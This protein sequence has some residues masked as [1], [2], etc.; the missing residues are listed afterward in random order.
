MILLLGMNDVIERYAEC[1]LDM[2]VLDGIVYYPSITLHH[3]EFHKYV[4][5]IRE[6]RPPIITTQNQEMIDVLLESDL[7][8]M[9]ITVKQFGDEIRS[10]RLTKEQAREMR[11]SFNI[12][13]RD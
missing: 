1:C 3:T 2:D 11:E 10:R 9:V 6:E 13:L 12:D 7:D 5:S 4:D 8:I